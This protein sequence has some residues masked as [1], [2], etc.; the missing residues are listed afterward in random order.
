MLH[1][2]SSH[3]KYGNWTEWSEIL[4]EIICVISKS[5]ERAAQV[6]LVIKS[7]ISDQNCTTRGSI[8]TL[9]HPFWNRLNTGLG[10]FK[11]F[12]RMQYWAGLKLNSFFFR[13]RDFCK[14]D[15]L[16][17]FFK[18][19]YTER[20][21][22]LSVVATENLCTRKFIASIFCPGKLCCL[23]LSKHSSYYSIFSG[24]NYK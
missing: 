7:M 16:S 18:L 12:I 22:W 24:F 10:Q 15:K 4:A 9:L 23:E 21:L 6:R 2:F 8:T 13:L 17:N 20:A 5:N 19:R 3:D 1:F 11:Y 14:G